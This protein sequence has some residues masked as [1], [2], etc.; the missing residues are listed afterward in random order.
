MKRILLSLLSL[1][2]MPTCFADTTAPVYEFVDLGLPSGTL[3]ATKNVGADSIHHPGL[4]LAWGET[5]AKT[6][7]SWAT[8]KWCDGTQSKMT[9]YVMNE[10]YGTVDN[11]KFLDAED[12]AAATEKNV[13]CPTVEEL[14]ELMDSKYCKWTIDTVKGKKGA[15]VTGNN[16]NSIFIPACGFM[17]NAR[18]SSNNSSGCLWSNGLTVTQPK[19]YYNANVIRY[20]FSRSGGISL[21]AGDHNGAGF[22]PRNYG[23]NIRPVKRPDTGISDTRIN[24]DKTIVKIYNISGL[25]IP[26]LQKGLNIVR[27][28]DGT[29]GKI[30]MK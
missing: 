26:Q 16:G 24:T 20:G 22:V 13:G 25:Q 17:T 27:Y 1:A 30:L 7:Y 3:W 10:E 28:S 11:K 5:Q 9:K 15:R 29:A 2:L 8:Y 19:Y 23:Y 12:D 18:L 4:Y 14:A 21:A 6:E